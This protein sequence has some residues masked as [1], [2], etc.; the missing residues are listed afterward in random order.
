[1]RPFE[2]LSE[3]RA[4]LLTSILPGLRDVRTPLACGYMWLVAAW[5]AFA[6]HLPRTRPSA[7]MAASI[8]D[9]GGHLGK[10]AVLAAIT[11]AAYLIGAVLEFDPTRL[12]RSIGVPSASSVLQTIRFGGFEVEFEEL[13]NQNREKG[14]DVASNTVRAD[15]ANKEDEESNANAQDDLE[16]RVEEVNKKRE[17][18]E[19]D[20]EALREDMSGSSGVETMQALATKLQASNTELFGRYDRLQAEASLRLNIAV[21]L[22]TLL[23]LIIWRSPLL[24]WIKLPLSLVPVVLAAILLRQSLLRVRSANQVL[25][26][27]ERVG[28][29]DETTSSTNS[30]S[31]M[32]S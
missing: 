1:M 16:R 10:A 18:I 13:A 8:W 17:S 12:W 14:A 27:A 23:E 29:F 19:R 22:A 7:G 26:M 5:L 9:L 25:I 30:Q 31:K 4:T 21:P 2:R 3:R 20:L 15:D 11:F 6:D 32:S 24:F 28:I